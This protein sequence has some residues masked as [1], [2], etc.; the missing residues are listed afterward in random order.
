MLGS[1]SNQPINVN[2][3][4]PPKGRGEFCDQRSD[5][6]DFLSDPAIHG[7][8][9]DHGAGPFVAVMAAQVVTGGGVAAA[10]GAAGDIAF[11]LGG[12]GAALSSR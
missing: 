11:A 1:I 3:A 7:I 6:D 10:S 9:V 2:R 8:T 4:P 5:R 12:S